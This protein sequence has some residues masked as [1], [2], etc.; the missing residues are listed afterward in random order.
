MITVDVPSVRIPDSY[1]SSGRQNRVTLQN[2]VT[3]LT[4]TLDILTRDHISL[5]DIQQACWQVLG[6]PSWYAVTAISAVDYEF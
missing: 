1:I 5:G 6:D 2:R 4:T 3:G